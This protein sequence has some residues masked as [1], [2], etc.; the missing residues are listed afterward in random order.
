MRPHPLLC[1]LLL[2][3]CGGG[4]YKRAYS[5]ADTAYAAP[6]ESAGGESYTPI[7]ENAQVAVADAPRSTFAI[8]VDTASM[9]N[10]RRF[11]EDG[12]LPPAD[13]VRIEEMVNY[14][15]YAY[16]D[17]QQGPFAVITEVGPSPF[18]TGRKLVHIGLQGKRL[19]AAETPAMN[20]VFLVDTSGSMADA[21][22]LPLLKQ[23]LK[24][25]V[26]EM[27]A[28][29][30]IGIV[31]YAGSAGVVLEPTSDR[32]AILAALQRLESGGSTAGAQ[33]IV[34]AYD[35]A[36]RHF[37]KR[38]INRVILATD[39]D[40]NVGV[41]NEEELVKLIEEERRGGVFLT[42]LGFGTGN[43]KDSRMEKLADHGNGNYAYIDTL[44][45][46]RKVL[47][48]EAGGTLVTIAQD[49]KVQVEFDEE[50]VAA[51]RLLGYENRMLAEQDFRNDAKDAGELGAGHSV[52]AIY[53]IEPAEHARANAALATVRLR[54]Q[55]PG[56][57]EA[58]EMAVEAVDRGLALG[59][60]SDDFRF[61]AAV[62]GFGML[63]R[64]SEQR[65]DATWAS[66]RDLARAAA[67]GDTRRIQLVS[68]VEIAARLAGSP[69]GGATVAR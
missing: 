35:L 21:D 9:S 29:D 46:A 63:L 1:L 62:A 50:Q 8:D 67:D 52:T 28:D 17:A 19:A 30:R 66:V 26:D 64:G 42:V 48:E 61:S 51:Y 23:G 12:A 60:T 6:Y 41:T 27:G 34:A 33:G 45:E 53:E 37:D 10:V 2:S 18:H 69:L 56:G 47:V 55:P 54:W 36:H 14:F 16:P 32:D 49:V 25:V 68:L 15:D 5:V 31:A 40:F 39:G 13:A 20:L 43:L 3:A 57:G 38:A 11:L 59:K 58:T 7:Q 24:L 44:A 65:G 4:S 22:R